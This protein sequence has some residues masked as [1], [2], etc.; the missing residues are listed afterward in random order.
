MSTQYHNYSP[1]QAISGNPYQ[2]NPPQHSTKKVQ[3]NENLFQQPITRR[4]NQN[5]EVT[6]PITISCDKKV[7]RKVKSRS[8]I[9]STASSKTPKANKTRLPLLDLTQ[10]YNSRSYS[11]RKGQAF[12]DITFRANGQQ[13]MTMD[14]SYS[15][16]TTGRSTGRST[17]RARQVYYALKNKRQYSQHNKE[18]YDFRNFQNIQ[19]QQREG[20]VFKNQ[21]QQQFV[22][23]QRQK[24]SSRKN[25]NSIQNQLSPNFKVQ[26]IQSQNSNQRAKYSTL[27]NIPNTQSVHYNSLELAFGQ[28]NQQVQKTIDGIEVK[29]VTI[30]SLNQMNIDAIRKSYQVQYTP[31][32][33]RDAYEIA[34][35]NEREIEKIKQGS[36]ASPKAKNVKGRR[37]KNFKKE[38][39]EGSRKQKTISA[40]TSRS[41]SK[42]IKK[43]NFEVKK[44]SERSRSRSKSISTKFDDENEKKVISNSQKQ[45]KNRIQSTQSHCKLNK[46]F[47][48]EPQTPETPQVL[49]KMIEAVQIESIKQTPRKAESISKKKISEDKN[50]SQSPATFSPFDRNPSFGLPIYLKSG[51]KPKSSAKSNKNTQSKMKLKDNNNPNEVF[52]KMKDTIADRASMEPSPST[53]KLKTKEV[54]PYL[55]PTQYTPKLKSKKSSHSVFGGLSY[56]TE[57]NYCDFSSLDNID[58]LPEEEEIIK[59]DCSKTTEIQFNS[60]ENFFPQQEEP[61][62][63]S[64]QQSG[65]IDF[66]MELSSNISNSLK[67]EKSKSGVEGSVRRERISKSQVVEMLQNL[68]IPKVKKNITQSLDPENSKNKA[69]GMLKKQNHQSE[70]IEHSIK[71]NLHQNLN[72]VI[73]RENNEHFANVPQSLFKNVSFNENL[74]PF[75]EN[76]FQDDRSLQSIEKYP[77]ISLKEIKEVSKQE[78]RGSSIA[79]HKEVFKLRSNPGYADSENFKDTDERSVVN[80]DIAK[81]LENDLRLS[82]ISEKTQTYS[83]IESEIKLPLTNSVVTK[84]SKR[85]SELV[86]SHCISMTP[87]E[88]LGQCNLKVTHTTS[89]Q[90]E[91]VDSAKIK[92]APPAME[93]MGPTFTIHQFQKSSLIDL[94]SEYQHFIEQ[95]SDGSVYKGYKLKGKKHGYGILILSNGSRYEGDWLNDVMSGIGKLFYDSGVLAYQ[96]GFLHNKVDGHGIMFNEHTPANPKEKPN[97]FRDLGMIGDSWKSFEGTFSKDMKHG[98]GKWVLHNGDQ[99]LGEFVDDKA[100]GRGT[101]T[102]TLKDGEFEKIAG[103]WR[104]N[105][106]I[107]IYN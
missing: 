40:S 51:S 43:S 32:S 92:S 37:E 39:S 74:N 27:Q 20:N 77:D 88:E 10:N 30:R 101:Y 68:D 50:V 16:Q 103:M 59:S 1:N 57:E 9:Q 71:K 48:L 55:T 42:K 62:S 67:Q 36:K 90:V 65:S 11:L 83:G 87:N 14:R 78:E 105:K 22:T 18:N 75:K 60:F 47:S 54:N 35:K 7:H 3:M 91:E 70:Y 15:P 76:Q 95:Y 66:T 46:D 53:V 25:Y 104:G 86:D 80:F 49:R 97:Y 12:N 8:F 6:N 5:V 17:D 61:S 23:P 63:K 34:L 33:T 72:S 13:N 31:N 21:K 79:S 82:K 58:P 89:C 94:D 85:E 19:V 99:F 69:K 41:R 52:L 2:F 93:E 24:V 84:Q 98:I 73:D 28:Q 26:S 102:I 100:E 38:N 81:E 64:P 96:G 106:L 29:A 107:E 56:A 4:I 44:V 45:V